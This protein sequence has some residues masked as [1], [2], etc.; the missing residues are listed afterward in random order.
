MYSELIATFKRRRTAGMLACRYSRPVAFV[1]IG[2]HSLTNLYPVIEQLRVPL[3]Y[4]CLH[5]TRLAP[6]VEQRFPGVRVVHSLDPVLSDPEVEAV[7][8]ATPPRAQYSLACQVLQSGKALFI[9]KPPCRTLAELNHLVTLPSQRVQ[10]G[11][12]KRYAPAVQT[13]VRHLRHRSLEHYTL[14]YCTGAYPE[15]NALTDLFIHPLDLV[16]FLFGPAQVA[17]V[18]RSGH[19]TLLVHL[20]HKSVV[21]A[22]ELSTDYSWQH[23]MEELTVVGRQ[24][25][26]HLQGTER[27]TCTPIPPSLVGV[28]VEKVFRR[29]ALEWTLYRR[30]TFSPI[31]EASTL[32]SEG[33]YGEVKA[34]MDAVEEGK[35]WSRLTGLASV[36]PAY[37]LMQQIDSW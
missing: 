37:E 12:Q 2:H 29:H 36:W 26:Y 5:S 24:G 21:G 34:F 16:V 9:E 8:V 11:M 20:L 25:V 3:R 1:G 31:P 22:L 15:G 13:L 28:P 6:L 32:V 18:V 30:E 27:L 35:G 7:F 23:P 14:R 33:F 10:V 19:G 4:I 17:G